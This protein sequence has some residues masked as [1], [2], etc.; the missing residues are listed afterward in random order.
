MFNCISSFA[1]SLNLPYVILNDFIACLAPINPADSSKKSI[2]VAYQNP[3]NEKLKHTISCLVN[4]L[5]YRQFVNNPHESVRE[6]ISNSL[7]AQVRSGKEDETINIF[8]NKRKLIIEDR[9]DGINWNTFINYFVPSRSSNPSAI[10][11]LEDGI[12]KVTGRFGQGGLAAYSYIIDEKD[13]YLPKIET[14]DGETSLTF[15]YIKEGKSHKVVF[16]GSLSTDVIENEDEETINAVKKNKI[17]IYTK[18]GLEAL[19]LKFWQAQG[20]IVFDIENTEKEFEG[21]RFKVHS[22]LLENQHESLE[23]FIQKTFCFVRHTPV[24]LNDRRINTLEGFDSFNSEG[25]SLFYSSFSRNGEVYVCEGGKVIMEFNIKGA[26]VPETLAIDF[27]SLPLTL[28]RSTLDFKNTKTLQILKHL[29]S[30]ILL[31]TTL[32]L[33]Q[34]G[35]LLNGLHP[36]LESECFNLCEEVKKQVISCNFYVLPD[37]KA[38]RRKT[39]VLLLKNDYLPQISLPSF[40]TQT[41]YCIY[42]TDLE[43]STPIAVTL[44]DGFYHLFLETTLLDTLSVFDMS[45]RLHI[46]NAWL[47]CKNYPFKINVNEIIKL[48]LKTEQSAA[49]D[50]SLITTV[51]HTDFQTEN[52][53]ELVNV[54]KEQFTL[55]ADLVFPHNEKGRQKL[56]QDFSEKGYYSLY[57]RLDLDAFW[58]NHKAEFAHASGFNMFLEKLKPSNIRIPNIETPSSVPDFIIEKKYLAFLYQAIIPYTSET[59]FRLL[60]FSYLLT[61]L[62]KG[63]KKLST[64]AP[65]L[66]ENWKILIV[67]S[68]KDMKQLS[69][70]KLDPERFLTFLS[71]SRQ[72][73]KSF[74]QAFE[75]EAGCLA[76]YEQSIRQPLQ[77]IIELIKIFHTA[78]TVSIEDKFF[79]LKIERIRTLAPYLELISKIKNP[80][81]IFHFLCYIEHFNDFDYLKALED[82]QFTTIIELLTPL[83]KYEVIASNF[84][85]LKETH[86]ADLLLLSEKINASSQTK[87]LWASMYFEIIKMQESLVDNNLHSLEIKQL[88]NTMINLANAKKLQEK[89]LKEMIKDLKATYSDFKRYFLYPY[90][91]LLDAVHDH[92]SQHP[93]DP[94]E[95]EKVE[96]LKQVQII[97]KTVDSSNSLRGFASLEESLQ[98]VIKLYILPISYSKERELYLSFL[99]R[100][101]VIKEKVRALIY[102]AFLCPR[103]QS[104]LNSFD[105]PLLYDSALAYPLHQDPE[106]IEAI[107]S[108][109]LATIRIHGAKKQ[110]SKEGAWILEII[111]NSIESGSTL[112]ECSSHKDKDGNYVFVSKDNGKGIPSEGIKALKS[113][114]VT[115]KLIAGDDRNFGWGFFTLFDEFDE[116]Q[117]ISRT[118]DGFETHLIFKKIGHEIFVQSTFEKTPQ[119]EENKESGVTLILKKHT[120]D[121]ILDTLIHQSHLINYCQRIQG[122]NITFN[123]KAVNESSVRQPII[124]YTLPYQDKGNI[125]VQ[126]GWWEGGIY[127]KGNRIDSI[128]NNFLDFLPKELKN[129]LKKDKVFISLSLPVMQQVLNRAQLANEELL[130]L[131]SQTAILNTCIE[132]AT[133]KLKEGKDFTLFSK[134]YWYNFS[135][136][137]NLTSSHPI[138]NQ[139][140]HNKPLEETLKKE[141]LESNLS[142]EVNSFFSLIDSDALSFIYRLQ[143]PQALVQKALAKEKLAT[144]KKEFQQTTEMLADKRMLSA[145][146][147]SLPL[148][149]NGVSCN[150]IRSSL[151]EALKKPK[152]LNNGQIL[153]YNYSSIN[154]SDLNVLQQ[155][156]NACINSVT[157]DLNLDNNYRPILVKFQTEIFT[158]IQRI[159]SQKKEEGIDPRP[160]QPLKLFLKKIAQQ[161]LHT[162]ID[163]VFYA[164]TDG[165]IAKAIGKTQTIWVN[166]NSSQATDFLKFF[167]LTYRETSIDKICDSELQKMTTW[168]E[169]LVHEMTHMKE[170]RGCED[171]HNSIFYK[172][173]TKIFDQLLVSISDKTLSDHTN[174][175]AVILN[176]TIEEMQNQPHFSDSD[177]EFG[178]ESDDEEADNNDL[179]NRYEPP[180]KYQKTEL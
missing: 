127:F 171:T 119:F 131:N 162:E 40:Y 143:D 33:Q 141:R 117:V 86:Y 32:T 49:L 18:R 156:I 100:S 98:Y 132:Y 72:N 75:C 92:F 176:E 42:L 104:N 55:L 95:N 6:L 136:L 19:K 30:N 134:D 135:K 94:S 59:G 9:G 56:I 31:S 4:N 36:L 53:N 97:A 173:M 68:L 107:G 14:I 153:E 113:P 102:S 130:L 78:T 167:S 67:E 83:D 116:V 178:S 66:F 91:H 118:K 29:I 161:L 114:G 109:S 21:T 101:G 142:S 180:K 96:I 154:I 8:L 11:N 147:F 34:K 60:N 158:H 140:I 84:I 125:N 69:K 172:H 89:D 45:S 85:Q 61:N 157:Q 150:T 160:Y 71:H 28:E 52:D 3:P 144:L 121:P 70:N 124:D 26:C 93:F 112:I 105:L 155:I 123:K 87:L 43:S 108:E 120:I 47:K 23:T 165:S 63:S 62:L 74:A 17:T 35:S 22:Y 122:L 99:E 111:K 12:P 110:I 13:T 148:I 10:F 73:T 103:P 177:D 88:L 166:L 7:D 146:L 27:D 80:A 137:N 41:N 46:I 128:R 175:L 133:K 170:Q 54:G 145:L 57:L 139:F 163:V 152:I 106:V 164:N 138:I 44:V 16:N 76:L 37:L 169:I 64:R 38:I 168:L 50:P 151:L 48:K 51:L 5:M 90:I 159:K 58:K 39:D 15:L 82:S 79:E 174:P 2:T 81:A 1:K 25:V 115:T 65:F 129:L 20:Q 77:E 126:I 149:P 179:K 24:S